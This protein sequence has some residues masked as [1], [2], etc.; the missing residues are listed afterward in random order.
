MGLFPAYIEDEEITE[1]L[2]DDL[3]TPREFGIDFAT[4]QLTGIVVEGIE[5][6]KVW[7][8]IALQVARYRYFICSWQY[9]SEIED[10]YGKGY[11]AEHLESEISRMIKECLLVNDYIEQVEVTNATYRLGRLSA[12]VTVTTIYDEEVSET[13][14]TEVA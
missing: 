5:A 14:E 10:L 13:Y 2:A 8:Y 11:S 3:A 4:G 9:G 1:E 7:I 12:T 6:I